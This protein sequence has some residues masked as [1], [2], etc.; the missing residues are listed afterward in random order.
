M[1]EPNQH[2]PDDFM[3]CAPSAPHPPSLTFAE[4]TPWPRS[5]EL[6]CWKE[7]CAPLPAVQEGKLSAVT[8][9]WRYRVRLASPGSCGH[10][11]GMAMNKRAIATLY[12]AYTTG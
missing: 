4:G 9:G 11:A 8:A 10:N 1:R 5:G 7:N 6:C 12:P 3:R 2:V